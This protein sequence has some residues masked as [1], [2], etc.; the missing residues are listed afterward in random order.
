MNRRAI[1]IARGNEVL[2]LLRRLTD[3]QGQTLLLVTHDAGQA[4]RADRLIRLRDGRVFETQDLTGGRSPGEL[5]RELKDVCEE[6]FKG[7][8]MRFKI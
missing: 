6:E 3:E 7:N 1:W 8:S 5:L 2:D 4:A